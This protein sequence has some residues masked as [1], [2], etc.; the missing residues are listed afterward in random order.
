MLDLSRPFRCFPSSMPLMSK[1]HNFVL[2][3][4]CFQVHVDKGM[5]DGQKITFRG[6]G[7][8]E[9]NVVAIRQWHCNIWLESV[10]DSVKPTCLSPYPTG[11]WWAVSMNQN[12]LITP[13]I[14]Q[15]F[16]LSKKLELTLEYERG[17]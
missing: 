3:K 1:Q 6:E 12:C 14:T 7:D 4:L 16:C 17:G 9:V 11:S 15:H 10:L 2:V 8:Q 13:L 5:N